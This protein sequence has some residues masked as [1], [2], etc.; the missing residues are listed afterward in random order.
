MMMVK[1]HE[2]VKALE[3]E[4]KLIACKESIKNE[5]ENKTEFK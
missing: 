2:N 3:D 4:T 5:K 1:C